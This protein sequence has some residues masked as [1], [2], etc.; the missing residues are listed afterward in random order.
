[1]NKAT[2]SNSCGSQPPQHTP[3]KFRVWKRRKTE[4]VSKNR[5]VP[6]QAS[7]VAEKQTLAV[8]FHVSRSSRVSEAHVSAK[9]KELNEQHKS[10]GAVFLLHQNLGSF[11]DR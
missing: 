6:V 4:Q 2:R 7:D 10:H 1:M 9:C 8:C 5:C 11:S 3:P